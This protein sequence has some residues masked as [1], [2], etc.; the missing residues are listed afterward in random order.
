MAHYAKVNDGIV[1]QVIVAEADFFKTFVDD[2]PGEWIQT[3]YNTRGGKHILDGTP[4]RYNFAGVGYHYDSKADAFYE[5]KPFK[6][7]VLDT[8][9][10]TWK[11]PTDMPDDGKAYRWDDDSDSWKE[12]D[13]QPEGD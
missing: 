8:E 10:Y 2:S 9:S 5:P 6:A 13:D 1:E 3:S 4:L 11:P 7:W 12:V